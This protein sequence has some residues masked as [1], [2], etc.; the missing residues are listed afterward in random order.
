QDLSS[1]DDFLLTPMLELDDQDSSDSS[2]SQVIALDT[3][4]AVDDQAATLLGND[5]MV[6]AAMAAGPGSQA[7]G[8]GPVWM[9]PA[10]PQGQHS[11]FTIRMLVLCTLVLSLSGMM[12][13]EVVRDMSSWGGTS[14]VSTKIIDTLLQPFEGK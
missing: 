13:F 10:S 7:M 12:I 1:D 14:A 8:P 11:G 6:G 3:E 2:G 9:L 4:S 5:P